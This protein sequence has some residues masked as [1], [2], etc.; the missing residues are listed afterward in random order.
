MAASDLVLVI[1]A[2]L[3][4]LRR[5]MKAGEQAVTQFTER[6][7]SNLRRF[8]KSLDQINASARNRSI[9]L[10]YQIQ[11]IV[12][13][14]STGTSVFRILAQQGGQ[15]ASALAG[16]EGA[17]GSV[18]GFLAGPWGAAILGAVSIGGLFLATQDKTAGAAGKNVAAIRDLAA[19]TNDLNAVNGTAART[20][21]AQLAAARADTQARLNDEIAIRKQT[22]ALLDQQF[23]KLQ[24]ARRAVAATEGSSGRRGLAILA[25][26]AQRRATDDLRDTVEKLRQNDE[27]IRQ[28]QQAL[29]AAEAS[30]ILEKVADRTDKAAAATHRYERELQKL[31]TQ[32]ESGAIDSKRFEALA[33]AAEARRDAAIKSA[34]DAEKKA[35]ADARLPSLRDRV[36]DFLNV[37]PQ[38]INEDFVKS[39]DALRSPIQKTRDDYGDLLKRLQEPVPTP[40]YDR[41]TDQFKTAQD[42][43]Q[44]FGDVL[45][46]AIN[47][48]VFNGANAGD[49]IKRLALQLLVVEPIIRRIRE[50][51]TGIFTSLFGGSVGSGHGGLLSG[52][53][54]SLFG[55]FFADGGTLGA[56]KWGI[57]GEAGPEIIRGPATIEPL[58]RGGGA[59][60][61]VYNI[62]A[63]GATD[64]Q[65]VQQQ[66]M[67]AL[68][69]S[70]PG[71]IAK[72]RASVFDSLGRQR[73]A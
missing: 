58:R 21:A 6:A 30:D 15:I 56:G 68:A 32:F 3:E 71:T 53:F 5:E 28:A 33:S 57:A 25:G 27:K 31:R 9:Q 37:K 65:L 12:A 61:V 26:E 17:L 52:L 2:N 7:Q 67:I 59:A 49:V 35:R 34:R 66:I 47:A 42:A 19:A 70:E 45:S 11:D 62:D 16:T 69:A 40:D 8:D 63:R 60:T 24:D 41:L 48:V 43:A 44:R 50:A 64:P 73:I 36:D 1:E 22:A 14:A 18:A 38:G 54:G 46:D 13:Q 29:R 55:G 4:L 20:A 72:A 10:G 39:L 51:S 23:A